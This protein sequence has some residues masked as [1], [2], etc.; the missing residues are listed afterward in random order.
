MAKAIS[1]ADL[2]NT[3]KPL[4][5]LLAAADKVIGTATK[6]S[7]YL[8]RER[9]CFKDISLSN[10]MT[11]WVKE[12]KQK[13]EKVGGD[14]N[15]EDAHDFFFGLFGR[16]QDPVKPVMVTNPLGPIMALNRLLAPEYQLIVDSLK[17]LKNKAEARVV[18]NS[19]GPNNANVGV[20]SS[21]IEARDLLESGNINAVRQVSLAMSSG[22]LGIN[23]YD[24]AA[25]ASDF[26]LIS[27]SM[28]NSYI[29]SIQAVANVCTD[30]ME[31]VYHIE[32][33]AQNIW[34]ETERTYK[35]M[36]NEWLHR[37][38]NR[39][40]RNPVMTNVVKVL[41]ND[42]PGVEEVEES[43]AQPR[44]VTPYSV[45][46]AEKLLQAIASPE[47]YK[48]LTKP[49]IISPTIKAR[50]SDL[51][52]VYLGLIDAVASY[53]TA[54]RNIDL[55]ESENRNIAAFTKYKIETSIREF[56][57][58][59]E[60]FDSID[61]GHVKPKAKTRNKELKSK[62]HPILKKY[63]KVAAMLDVISKNPKT[64]KTK[65][66]EIY[67]MHR[68]A[69]LNL[70]RKPEDDDEETT[71]YEASQGFMGQMEL[72]PAKRPNIKFDDIIGKSFDET[73]AHIRSMIK[74]NTYP[75]LY[76]ATSPSKTLKSNMLLVGPPGSGKTEVWRA[77]ASEGKQIVVNVSGSALRS[78]WF[79]QSEQNVA[80]LAN[81]AEKLHDK[82]GKIVYVVIDEI[83]NV[84]GIPDE[85]NNLADVEW[86]IIK[87]FQEM[88]D[89]VKY[90]RGVIWCGATN[91][92]ERLPISALRRFAYV[93]APGEL[94]AQERAQILKHY[95][96][97]GLP[98]AKDITDA[99]FLE[100]GKRLDGAVGDIVRKMVDVIH[101]E[102]FSTFIREHPKEAKELEQWLKKKDFDVWK[103]TKRDR[104][105][106][107]SKI[108]KHM[109]VTKATLE[110]AI[111]E[112]LSS[113]DIIEEIKFGKATY[114]RFRALKAGKLRTL[115]Q[116]S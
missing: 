116:Y 48:Y 99:D 82:T 115:S 46:R 89:G 96:T 71:Y 26:A 1:E 59:L 15:N 19:V 16:K 12:K 84:L 62:V 41:Y 23:A 66:L 108:A 68:T 50:L 112:R 3:L 9:Q 60:A 77:L 6:N 28:M 78:M 51:I 45:H 74:Y 39:V 61:F 22:S 52:E 73:K 75:A 7:E 47:I 100:Y 69:R 18:K 11:E 5:D 81:A 49:S 67:G 87:T 38:S 104:Q 79:G 27:N 17:T 110:K 70:L 56:K 97:L 80:S 107:K 91:N 92:P 103:L 76:L 106:I 83:D 2:L 72:I 25:L 33:R 29:S 36:S 42:L 93:E 32:Q 21:I 55:G 8:E 34:R 90:Y 105:H 86:R 20:P 102:T 64:A 113:P 35:A 24:T 43:G 94:T 57:E 37:E 10:G 114:E 111:S 40:I 109:V 54:L 14:E 85:G 95:L 30:I 65:V 98:I 31:N 63:D 58:S 4:G 44:Q 13:K 101:E 53:L 88:L